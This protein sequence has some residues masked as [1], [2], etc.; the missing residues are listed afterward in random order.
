MPTLTT[1]EEFIIAQERLQPEARGE[2]SQLLRDLVLG[3]KV[4]HRE[5]NRAGLAGVLGEYGHINVQGEVQQKLDVLANEQ[6]LA[7]LSR[8]CQVAAVASEESDTILPLC[9][10]GK[11]VVLIDPL[12]GSSNIDVNVSIGTIFAIY[13]RLSPLGTPATVADCLQPGSAQLAAG[14]V[15]YGSSTMLVYTTGSGVNGFTYEA[16]LGEFFLSHPNI[17]IPE[18]SKYYSINDAA[19]ERFPEGLKVY[20]SDLKQRNT[21]AKKPM[22]PRY[23]GSLVADFHRNL[24]QGGI[25]IYPGS[26]DRPEGKL[27]LLYE[28]NPMAFIAEQAGGQASSGS[29]RI[30]ALQPTE[31]HQRCPLYIGSPDEMARVAAC[32]AAPEFA[33]LA[34]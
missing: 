10:T 28:C 15:L 26:V 14:Y 34:H 19:Y 23:I 1:L 3:A 32:L 27:R 21:S 13:R 12:D 22:S 5:V 6:F 20:L 16:S 11:Y 2:F 18:A 17:R 29:Q 9:D 8:G 25:F 7:A 31:L 24:L 4:V 30:L 33:T